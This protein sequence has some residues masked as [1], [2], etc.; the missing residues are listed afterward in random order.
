MQWKTEDGHCYSTTDSLVLRARAIEAL[1]DEGAVD[2]AALRS[3]LP[4]VDELIFIAEHESIFSLQLHGA[5]HPTLTCATLY[6]TKLGEV[7]V[8]IRIAEAI[9]AMSPLRMQPLIRIEAWRLLARCYDEVAAKGQALDR[10]IEESRQV[11]YVFMERMCAAD[12]EKML[13]S[14]KSTPGGGAEKPSAAG[15]VTAAQVRLN[16]VDVNSSNTQ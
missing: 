11:G 1:V 4:T 16:L 8:A 6:A 2:A 12:R 14:G 3:W 10:A 9:L 15:S 5:A 7:E 13:P